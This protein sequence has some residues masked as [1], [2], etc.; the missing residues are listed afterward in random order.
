MIKT[1]YSF[2]AALILLTLFIAPA[3]GETLIEKMVPK[4]ISPGL[5]HLAELI[6][7]G[8]SE[9]FDL[10]RIETILNFIQN[11]KPDSFLYYPEKKFEATPVL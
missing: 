5:D 10:D 7:S 2:A 1:L 11:Q 3:S 6:C 4:S 8:T 9:D